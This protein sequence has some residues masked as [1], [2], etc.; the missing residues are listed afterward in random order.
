MRQEAHRHCGRDP[1]ARARRGHGLC[2]DLLQIEAGAR[3]EVDLSEH[4]HRDVLIE[5]SVD[6]VR[7][8]G[9][10]GRRPQST[11]PRANQRFQPLRN[12]EICRE[13]L[14]RREN[15]ATTGAQRERTG[16]E[17]EEVDRDGVGHQ[18]LARCS[19]KQ[20]TDPIAKPTRQADPVRV[21]PRC[22]QA[23]APL[24]PAATREAESAARVGTPRE[25][26]SR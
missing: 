18:R 25:L 20:R 15:G 14:P 22:N 19:A 26:P 12:V 21:V 17:F 23:V 10:Q 16:Q 2:G 11:A 1:R 24:L 13:I 3:P 6:T 5:E 9:F 7:S 8:E 4:E